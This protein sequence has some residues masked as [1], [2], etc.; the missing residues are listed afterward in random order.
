MLR[1]LPL[2]D[3]IL[4]ERLLRLPREPERVPQIGPHIRVIPSLRDA[5]RS[6]PDRFRPLLMIVVLS[7]HYGVPAPDN[8]G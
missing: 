7:P 6:C 4:L 5:S 8:L 3:R 1:I 2:R